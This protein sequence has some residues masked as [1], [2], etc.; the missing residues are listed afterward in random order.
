[1]CSLMF[2]Y[3]IPI[4][5]YTKTIYMYK[6]GH[7]KSSKLPS[8]SID[9]EENVIFGMWTHKIKNKWKLIIESIYS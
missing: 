2:T 1:M 4:E 7:H 6:H 9:L 8:N 3:L 5:I